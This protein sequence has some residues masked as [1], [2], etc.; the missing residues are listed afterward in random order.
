MVRF[1]A[2]TVAAIPFA[3][4]RR[5]V[6]EP[7]SLCGFVDASE[8][9]A[10]LQLGRARAAKVQY[11]RRGAGRGRGDIARAVD[12][13]GGPG[14]ELAEFHPLTHCQ[15]FEKAESTHVLGVEDNLELEV[16]NPEY[17]E[18]FAQ[19][20]KSQVPCFPVFSPRIRIK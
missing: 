19:T 12:G 13:M 8:G 17:P 15:S 20:E 2:R 6:L 5:E 10:C 4:A 14:V 11:Q 16:V 3:A 1:P 7:M 9:D 18:N